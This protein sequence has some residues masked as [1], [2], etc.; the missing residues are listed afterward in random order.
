MLWA[1]ALLVLMVHE[2]VLSSRW[3]AVSM[4]NIADS[5]VRRNKIAYNTLH[6]KEISNATAE[7]QPGETTGG[8]GRP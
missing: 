6:M 5:D 2:L 4:T 1:I 3:Y 7:E 8:N